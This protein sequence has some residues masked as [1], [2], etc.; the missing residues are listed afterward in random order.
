MRCRHSLCRDVARID[1]LSAEESMEAQ[2]HRITRPVHS[3]VCASSRICVTLT[4][5]GLREDVIA[6]KGTVG[7]GLEVA[8]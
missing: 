2:I 7:I 3:A 1:V 6:S 5:S 4:Y 8:P